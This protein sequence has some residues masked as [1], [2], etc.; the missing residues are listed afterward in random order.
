[1]TWGQDN[2]EDQE[3]KNLQ[4]E[5]N[6]QRS[7]YQAILKAFGGEGVENDPEFQKMVK[8]GLK[9]PQKLLKKLQD[10]QQKNGKGQTNGMMGSLENSKNMKI[11]DLLKGNASA[12]MKSMIQQFNPISPQQLKVSLLATTEGKAL[13]EFLKNNPKFLDFLVGALKHPNALPNFAKILDQ[14]QKLT[15]FV[16]A[17]IFVFFFGM[18]YKRVQRN[19]NQDREITNSVNQFIFRLIFLTGIR[20]GIFVAFFH[21][22][23]GDIFGVFKKSFLA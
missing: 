19:R 21:N 13:G 20:F 5:L 11:A 16:G 12:I 4:K 10:I 7:Q 14:R 2:I 23:A 22:E 3:D 8:E 15:Y 17:N 9:D 1:V 18:W 6:D